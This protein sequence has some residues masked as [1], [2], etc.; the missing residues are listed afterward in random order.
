MK[1]LIV[2]TIENI[3]MK[4]LMNLRYLVESYMSRYLI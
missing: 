4:L 3:M 1:P 2:D